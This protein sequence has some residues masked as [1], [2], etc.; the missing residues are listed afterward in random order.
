MADRG[1]ECALTTEE[2]KPPLDHDEDGPHEA[3]E[4]L[5]AGDRVRRARSQSNMPVESRGGRPD[6]LV[7]VG[8]CR[9]TCRPCLLTSPPCVTFLAIIDHLSMIC[10]HWEKPPGCSTLFLLFELL[11]SAPAPGHCP[12]TVSML[13]ITAK[14]PRK[15]S[16]LPPLSSFP[17]SSPSLCLLLLEQPFRLFGGP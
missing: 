13:T 12:R 9:P 7:N 4:G 6:G 17:A 11:L 1:R 3:N 5:K 2:G 8:L 15:A 10:I 16:A 14:P